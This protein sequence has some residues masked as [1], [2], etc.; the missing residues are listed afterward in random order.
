MDSRVCCRRFAAMDVGACRSA[1]LRPQLRAIAASRL[2]LAASPLMLAASRLML[3]VLL[4][5]S[6]FAPIAAAS[7]L[8]D[9]MATFSKASTTQTEATVTALLKVGIAEHRS[10]EAMA[11]VQT[12]LNRNHL[13]SP[14]GLFHAARAAELSGQWQTAVGLYQRLLQ[15]VGVDQNSA[16]LATT[17]TYRLLLNS[18]G[19]ENAAYLLMRK[20]GNRLRPYGEAKR[21]DRWFL[22]QATRRRDLIAVCDRLVM[23]V[24]DRATD[25]TRFA[26][27]LRWLCSQYEQFKKEAP[28]AYAAALRLAA[29]NAPA[30]F[31]ARL[32]WV[33]TVMPYN[34]QLD[35]LR[36][37]SAPA[38]PKLTDAPLAAAAELLR[39]DPDRGAILV[40]QG[41]GVEYDH[42]HSGNCQ[43]RFDI[44]GER[45]LAQLLG[46]LPRM[47][48]SKRDDLLAFEIAQ[49]RVKF[50]PAAVRKAAI[51]FPGML[52][53]LT[54]ADVP[55]F[56]KTITVEEAKALAPQLARNPHAQ[57]A[58]VRA[59]ARPD[60][61]YSTVT[62]YMIQSEMW[63]FNDVK[64]LT[65][66]L[67][68]SGMFERDVDHDVPIKKYANLDSRYQQLKKLVDSTANSNDRLA[69]LNALQS[70]LLNASPRLPGALSL[71]DELF[72]NA[73]N[74]DKVKMLTKLT[75]D[76]HAGLMNSS[77]SSARQDEFRQLLARAVAKSHFGENNHYATLRLSPN[78]HDHWYH[79]WRSYGV[80]DLRDSLP[81]FAAKLDGLLRQQAKADKLSGPMLSM[82]MHCVEPKN[83]EAKALMDVLKQSAAYER[84]DVAYYEMAAHTDLFGPSALTAKRSAMNPH[85]VNRELLE[86]PNEATPAQ[87]EA[88]LKAVVDRAAKAV[89]PLP[90]IGLQQVAA[91]PD[92]SASTRGLVLSLFKE[93][94]P[95]GPYPTGQ[96][97]EALVI[98]IAKDTQENQQ[99]GPL[100]P[101][102][103]G[104]WQAA[105]A[106]DHPQSKGAI[107]L[108]LMTEAA[109][110][111][112]ASSIAV[113]FCR[114]A[115]RGPVGRKLFLQ[116]DWGIPDIKA[117]I[118]GISGKAALAIGVIDI[119]VDELDP[120]YPVYKSQSEFALGNV[121][122]AWDL[123][124][125]N[126]DQLQPV[127]RQLTVGYCLW[128]LERNIEDRD[129]ER[130]EALVKELT[131][132]SRQAAG[133]FTAQQEAD[134]KIAYADI[135][136]QKGALQTAR[137][138]Y[139][140]VADA[141]EH[142][143]T[144]LQY[145]AALRSVK[146]DRVAKNFG[147]ALAELDKLMLIRD[148]D[149]RKRTHFARAEVF[150]DQEKYADAYEEVSA[151]L[152]REP[153][154]ADAL[155]LLGKAQLEMR[156]LVD[157]SEIE[158]GVSRDQKLI[159]PGETIKINLNDP[160]LSVSGVGADIEVEIWAASGDR[161]RVMLH[162]LGDDK[163]KFRA[164]MPTKLAPPQTGD[165]VLQLLGRD[166]V[167]Y[168]YSERFRAKMADLPPDPQVVIG[169]ASDARLDVS[170]GAFP[171]RQG[172]RRLNLEELGIS[173]A[174]QALGTRQVRPGNPVYV[175]VFDPDQSTTADVDEVIVSLET[176]SGDAI[177]QLTLTETGTHTGE[178]EAIVPTGTA[179]AL[180]FASESAP[181]RDA[182]MVIS[183]AAYPGWAG[184]V[185]SKAEERLLSVDLNDNV[186][187]DKMTVRC[188]DPTL[189]PTH[190]VL[191]TSLN[192]RDWITRARYPDDPAPWDGRPR[193]SSFPT[194]S[195]GIAISVPEDRHLPEDWPR[196]MEIGSAREEI[197][198]NAITVPGLS[199]MNVELPSG[200]HPGYP[201][202]I[203]YRA[204]F[205]QPAAAIR[206]FRLTGFPPGDK[207]QT[208]FLLDGQ[209]A[210]EESDDPLTIVRELRPG[211]H[212]IQVWRNESRAELVK[213]K[214]QLLCDVS[215]QQELQPCP[216]NMFDPSQF[217][218]ALRETIAMP[219]TI[220]ANDAANE[221]ATQFDIA[222][223]GNTQARL[224]RLVIVGHQGAAPAVEKITLTDREGKQRLPVETDYR[225]LRG[226]QQLEV[227]PGDQ[228]SV[229]YE[230]DRVVTERRVRHERRLGVAYNTAT[231]SASFLNYETTQE[232][233][234]LVLEGIRRFELDD[235]V[236]IVV[237]DPDLDQSP[238]P[239]RLEFSVTAS[240]GTPVA[241]E[242]LET[243]PHSGVFLG[244]VFPVSSTPARD[245]EIQVSE[246]G[247]LTAT[248]RDMENLDPG[249]P[250]ERSVTIEHAYYTTPTLEVFNISSKRLP[251]P[252]DAAE[253]NGKDADDEGEPGP[254][255]VRPRRSLHYTRMDP[256]ATRAETLTALMGASLRFDV[257]ATHLAF[258]D[259]SS[260]AAYVQTDAG[261]KAHVGQA[262][263]L[264][265]DVRV[266][267]TLKLEGR[268]SRRDDASVR[269]VRDDDGT[270]PGYVIGTPASPPSNQPPL[271]EGRFSFNVPLILDDQPT[272]SYATQA[273]E[274]L[275]SSQ[276]P[277]GLA[278]RAGDKV[279][280]GYAYQDE[281][282]KAHWHT[283]TV[284]LDS[285]AF[286]DVMNAR[287]RRNL[288]SAYVGEKLYVRLIAPGLDRG[289]DR[290]VTTVNLKA[291]SGAATSFQLRETSPHSGDFKGSFALGYAAQPPSGALPSVELHGF[292]VRYGDQITVSVSGKALT[293]GTSEPAASA[294][295]LTIPAPPP[296]RH[297][298]INKGADG[299][300]EPFSKRFT[301][302]GVAIKTTFT[303]AECF[304]ELAKHHRKMDQES[305]ARR[306]MGHAQKLLAEAIASHHD[307]ELRAHAEYLLGNL[308]QEYADLSKNDGSKKLMYQDAL[309][310]FSKIPLDYPEAEFAPKAQFKKALVYEKLG[311]LDIAV[312][313]YVKLAYKYPEHELIPS[314]MSRLGS[315][316]Q[317]QGLTYKT[318]AE[319][320]E[321]KEG[322]VE[323]AGE[324]LRLRELA[325]QEY[326]D[327]AQVFAKL[328]QRF[329]DDPLAGLA[330]LRSAQNFMRAGDFA[331]AVERFQKV[332]DTE[333]YDGKTIRS[334]AV[335]WSGISQERLAAHGEAYESYRRLTFDF[336]DS[337]WAK[338]G[339]GR[340]A[341]PVFAKIIEQ[342][343][344]A[345]E[346]LLE[347]LKKQR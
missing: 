107:A 275:P 147:S 314:V 159:V 310:R 171:A 297:V 157:A 180:A 40:A 141:E 154:H 282:G 61:N 248:Y 261:R 231:I 218:A 316:F 327:A 33:A 330:G 344:K 144:E 292:P 88:A 204:I 255:I 219:A 155:I 54:A 197:P 190:F 183:A 86:L 264:P 5:L 192:G 294:L 95:L 44:D 345:R 18:I 186:P 131:I 38:D 290:D 258:A 329:P 150:F 288:K 98:R 235:S 303:L 138:W 312:E 77:Q 214:P 166:S 17:A 2:F 170:A 206:T 29:A 49:N 335:Y 324:A 270:P 103:D 101:Y 285:H 164:E 36:N 176:S 139:R 238:A 276:I 322:D 24:G 295:P 191:Q 283:A 213:R 187:L 68:H 39:L 104:L 129:T 8:D 66:G 291:D 58:M 179:Q 201:N 79:N 163:T 162:Q 336:P 71:W 15:T 195:R 1:G 308:A 207:P 325:T 328:E 84:L 174:Q 125:K 132:W 146:V 323:A 343:N 55:L 56:D 225:Q 59:W 251:L 311:E 252:L 217:P 81:E 268:L 307:D 124:D 46:V 27:D 93:N 247:T 10:A 339:R 240:G 65:H 241:F 320:L 232:G 64:A 230:D 28:D 185:G 346:Q 14:Q 208:I 83:E 260:I 67:W 115:L 205:H 6:F 209:P 63:R 112:D 265:F 211:L 42:G 194:Y 97:Y 70:D 301:E 69:A 347:S 60:R 249:I 226:N 319:A 94:A 178:F 306:E 116:R 222:F 4:L 20:E 109:L 281:Q 243:G 114:T 96:G 203:R 62:D 31:K 111:D 167:R 76:L 177:T 134:L 173:T 169:V 245:S 300:I 12:W 271:D 262:S 50:D 149:L 108:S 278:V 100:E 123:Y 332:I 224:V 43:K 13:Q 26:E 267:G 7:P 160:T 158:L 57:A 279:H 19:D 216:D 21:F 210:G 239:D 221:V 263:S 184:E 140:R 175:R 188:A 304:F 220:T 253:E 318:Q 234:Q 244:R 341:D 135:A 272:R 298:T 257:V 193:I 196:K 99:W 182:N 87:V 151:V 266:P 121:V 302:N 337:I 3:A 110:N 145:Q 143:G 9:Q 122:T 48:A 105:A 137:A 287:Y 119:P 250:T 106:K 136:F 215:G 118:G 273:A 161:E 256:S 198:Y 90:V 269:G 51:Q 72:T 32:K 315:Y 199:D 148:D 321:K 284:T 237:T 228:I 334:Q 168:G 165:K 326:L 45:K 317:K 313:E 47:S 35:E 259:S 331:T 293:A 126:A 113:T 246:G 102:A 152:K 85:V 128:L 280:I 37:A 274:S 338:Y 142:Q 25:Q 223:G 82:W 305:L 41:W 172:E 242:A 233:R 254:Q 117:R 92:W 11:A 30:A 16:G 156:K 277:D 299:E 52:N 340:L 133:T 309:A 229:R 200:G 342:E 227:I 22:D 181:G 91:L 120:A 127:V 80:G 202:L 153:S 236:A 333:Q 289:P 286:L 74:P 73:P 53:S 212:E 189:A 75:T 34:Q 130:A 78:I 89:I 296:A 23:I